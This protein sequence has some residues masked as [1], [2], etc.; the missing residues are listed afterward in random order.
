MIISRTP[1]RISLG[2]GG[3]DIDKFYEDFGKGFWIS[4]AIDKHIY[5][6][7]K[8]RFE[9]KI[10]LS[11]ANVEEVAK[12]EHIEHPIIRECLKYFKIKDHVEITCI[13]DLPSRIG[14]G[15]SGA[16]TVGLI[17]AL[18]AFS[19]EEI[20]PSGIASLA[21]E[22]EHDILKRPI[23]W[24]DSWIAFHGGIRVFQI[25]SG[26]KC[27]QTVKQFGLTDTDLS[28]CL[29]LFYTGIRRKAENI[30]TTQQ[31]EGRYKELMTDIY[32]LGLESYEALKKN[33]IQWFGENLHL[34]WLVKKS[35]PSMSNNHFEKIY[36]KAMDSGFCYGGKVVGAGGGGCFLF[37]SKNMK[38]RQLLVGTLTKI[39]YVQHIP[40]TF[41]TTGSIA[42]VI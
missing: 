29:S 33:N 10:K 4:G 21:Y 34:H 27:V 23:G 11:Y 42:S 40:F 3:T 36:K 41:T 32:N 20:Y 16:F 30:L 25:L 5:I 39:E 38:D 2:G 22:I 37:C 12:V 18:N 7:I 1:L 17:T 24:Q 13:S 31:N 15:S 14:L 8:P 9:K 35:F 6:I 19:N 26:S 28:G